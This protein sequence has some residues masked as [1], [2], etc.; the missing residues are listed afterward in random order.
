MARCIRLLADSMSL[1]TSPWLST[2]GNF[3]GSF[4]R[5]MLSS[6]SCRFSVFTKKNLL[7]RCG[8]HTPSEEEAV[9]AVRACFPLGAL[10]RPAQTATCRSRSAAPGTHLPECPQLAYT[11]HSRRHGS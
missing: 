11:T 3:R 4:G 2:V 8:V 10:H 6:R 5:G 9:P 1:V 7:R